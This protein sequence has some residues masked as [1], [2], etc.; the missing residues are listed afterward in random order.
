[1]LREAAARGDAPG[2]RKAAHLIKGTSATI[3]ARSFAQQCA[4]VEALCQAGSLTDAA[5]QVGAI[6]E[7]YRKVEAEI[8]RW[9]SRHPAYD[10]EQRGDRRV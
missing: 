2:L 7:S 6:E 3:G 4:A 1:M 8:R 5:N 10:S 9:Q